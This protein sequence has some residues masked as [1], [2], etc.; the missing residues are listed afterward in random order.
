MR[1]S[2]MT[3]PKSGRPRSSRARRERRDRRYAIR[4]HHAGRP[5]QQD[6]LRRLLGPSSW[7]CAPHANPHPGRDV[8]PEEEL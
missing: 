2:I 7:R 8:E 6:V 3:T 1:P 4:L 5:E